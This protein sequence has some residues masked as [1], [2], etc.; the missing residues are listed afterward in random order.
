MHRDKRQSR[1]K[2]IYGPF[3]GS[4]S[5]SNAANG[6]FISNAFVSAGSIMVATYSNGK[7]VSKPFTAGT[8]DV[9]VTATGYVSKTVS[10]FVVKLGQ[11]NVLDVGLIA[12]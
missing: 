10:G 5:V 11:N 4:G 9:T 3:S 8:Y 7:F 12:V 6:S 2:T 1:P